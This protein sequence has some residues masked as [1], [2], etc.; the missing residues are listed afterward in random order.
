[1]LQLEQIQS[2][3][4]SLPD[5][6]F[7]LT[8]SGRYAAIFGGIDTRYYHDGSHLVGQMIAD[9]LTDE[10]TAW[11]LQIIESALQ[12]RSLVIVEYPLGRGDIKGLASE[13][14][15]NDLW[16]EGRVQ[17]LDFQVD[18]EDAVL[19]VASNITQRHALE[20]QLRQQSE[21]D[22][23]TGLS[24]RR[25]MAAAL[26]EALNV[27][28]RYSTPTSILIFDVDHFKKIND[29]FGHAA[30]DK[31]LIEIA[32]VCRHTLRHTDVA[33]RFGGDEFVILMS[34]TATHDALHLAD[35]L[36]CDIESTLQGFVPNL[37]ITISGGL[38]EL[39]VSDT[40]TDDVL[41]RA[42]SA[43][44]Q[45]KKLGRNRIVASDMA[46]HGLTPQA[47]EPSSAA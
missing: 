18:G 43:L 38:S 22:P 17:A 14:P 4:K 5:P 35:R 40:S 27:F 3:M 16:F 15:A 10:K 44:Y 33:L 41:K 45:A 29:T 9:V 26:Q 2:V 19:W 37:H 34:H 21:T 30:G 13:G 32:S 36:R 8:R 23:L 11:F 1:M 7:I 28:L 12:R 6:V 47:H 39:S 24:N 42:D 31:I 20:Q 46:R 25:Y